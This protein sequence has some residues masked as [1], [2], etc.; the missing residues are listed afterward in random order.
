MGI[1]FRVIICLLV[2]DYFQG[3]QTL[4]LLVYRIDCVP[5]F[6]KLRKRIKGIKWVIGW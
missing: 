6:L 5:I 2:K 1:G 4:N 3:L